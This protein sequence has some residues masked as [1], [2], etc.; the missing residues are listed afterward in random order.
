MSLTSVLAVFG[1]GRRALD[2]LPDLPPRPH[3]FDRMEQLEVPVAPGLRVHVRACGAGPPLLLVHGMMTSAYSFR[4]V[5]EALGARYRVYVPDLPGAGRTIAPADTDMSPPALAH[6]LAGLIDGLGLDRP[7]V[8]GNS[9][10]G[11]LSIWLALRHPERLGRLLVMHS[12]GFPE[13]RLRIL[14]F[15]TRIPGARAVLRRL[16]S[17]DPEGFVL[18]NVHYHDETVKSREETREY[19]RI[20]RDPVQTEL[21]FKVLR[22]TLDTRAMAEMH[23]GLGAWP[24]VPVGLLWA[25]EDVMVPPWTGARYSAALPAAP[26]VW[27]D[28][29]SHFMQVDRPEETVRQILQFADR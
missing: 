10:G 6:V 13:A 4:Y 17:G 18:R 2:A 29:A 20:F 5:A 11:Y 25:K 24:A 28:D 12:P 15:A 27:M 7:Y 9:L 22:D 3:G 26:I 8:V 19:G 16:V 21:F 14:R 23:R 1:A